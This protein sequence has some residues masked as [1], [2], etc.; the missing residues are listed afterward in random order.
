MLAQT[1]G[2]TSTDWLA[3][4]GRLHPVV[5]HLPIGLLA[6]IVIVELLCLGRSKREPGQRGPV[7]ARKA[8]YAAAAVSAVIAALTGWFLGEESTRDDLFWHRW[9]GVALA[10]ALIV[11]ASIDLFGRPGWLRG[12]LLTGVLGLATVTGHL[13]GSLTHGEGFLTRYAPAWLGGGDVAQSSMLDVSIDGNAGIALQTFA[14]RCVECHGAART[15]GGLRLDS[16]QGIASAVTPGDAPGSELF[17]RITLAAGHPDAM[18]PEG[19]PLNGEQVLAIMRWINEGASLEALTDMRESAQKAASERA[20]TLETVRGESGALIK[21]LERGAQP[22]L[23]VDFSLSR[24]PALRERLAALE[25]IAERV[26][27]LSLA[28]RELDADSVSGAPL[29][30]KLDQLSLER[31]TVDDEA[32]ALLLERA[33]AVTDLN[34]HSTQ[35]TSASFDAIVSMPGLTRVVLFG[36]EIS[37][38]QIDELRAARPSLVVT[39]GAG[40]DPAFSQSTPR[41][42]LAADASKRRIALLQETTIGRYETLWEHEIED[43]HDLHVLESGNVLFQTSWTQI[44]EA[45]PDT[46][47]IVWSYDAGEMNRT[48]VSERVEVHAFQRLADGVTM[49]AES[50]PARIIEIDRD[51]RLLAAVPLSVDKPDPHHD[52]RLARKTRAGTYL[53]AHENDGVVREYDGEG[54]VVWSYNVPMFGL[55]RAPGSGFDAFGN[56]VFSAIRLDNGNTLI[57]TGNGHSVLEV[58]RSGEIVWSVTQDELEG[59][60][61]AWVTTVQVLP[62][63]NIVIGNCHAGEEQPQLI[64]VTRGKNVVWRF[65]DFKRFGNELSNAVVIPDTEIERGSVPDPVPQRGDVNE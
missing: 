20:A 26:V 7:G 25:P 22:G 52:T 11:V 41:R 32:L 59:V 29:M 30:P 55:A 64:E 24:E 33:P 39:A 3:F 43:I 19:D 21:P 28:G 35:V 40:L 5:L 15:K 38:A 37:S 45:D 6:A 16:A 18:P 57:G 31:S 49:I 56:Q 51:G 58:T 46:G 1:T 27:E 34:L 4:A 63:G 62:G 13:G 42:L 65:R 17:R 60:R 2:G 23:R 8:L 14:D 54:R 53:V 9:L 61:L 47:E 36:T 44:V 50:G 10:G 48:S 12:M